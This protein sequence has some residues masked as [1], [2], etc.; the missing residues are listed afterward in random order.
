MRRLLA[1]CLVT[2]GLAAC[3]GPAPTPTPDEPTPE[4]PS[5][6]TAEEQTAEVIQGLEE[7]YGT[8]PQPDW[9]AAINRVEGTLDVTV[10][11]DG[12]VTVGALLPNDDAGIAVAETMCAAIAALAYD[13]NGDPIGFHDVII[14]AN[15]VDVLAD[16]DVPEL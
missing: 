16:C 12:W 10:G 7:V 2:I 14:F 13:E 3:A 8:D 11:D 4:A 1:I 9:W 6:L 15:A 5:R